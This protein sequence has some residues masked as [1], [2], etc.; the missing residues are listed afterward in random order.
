[1]QY[2]HA[3]IFWLME[4]GQQIN[5]VYNLT[6]LLCLRSVRLEVTGVGTWPSERL[7]VG[8][9][10]LT[11]QRDKRLLCGLTLP[12]M[13]RVRNMHLNTRQRLQALITYSLFVWKGSNSRWQ[14]GTYLSFKKGNWKTYSMIAKIKA[15]PIFTCLA[16]H[17]FIWPAPLWLVNCLELCRLCAAL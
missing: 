6:E 10:T 11:H 1:M 15:E 7:G 17:L 14:Q 5:K 16:H 4:I 8:L 13:A 2:I 9:K 12:E 3:Y